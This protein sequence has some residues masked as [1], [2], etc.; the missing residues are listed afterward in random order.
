MMESRLTN[1]T[2]APGKNNPADST[3]KQDDF[4]QS[5][6][7]AEKADSNAQNK[8]TAATASAEKQVSVLESAKLYK[9]KPIKFSSNYASLGPTSTALFNTYQTYT[10]GSG[11]IQ[12]GSGTPLN[13]LITMGISD[14]MEDISVN[15]GLKFGTNL[16]DNEWLISYQNKKR[17][18]DWGLT[19]YRNVEGYGVD[20]YD[21]S[22]LVNRAPLK[23]FTNIY[24]VNVAYPFDVVKSLRL[25]AG[26]RTDNQVVSSAGENLVLPY[27]LYPLLLKDLKRSYFQ[28]HLEFVYDNSQ[29]V[30]V[31]IW[32]GLRYKIFMDYN[33]EVTKAKYSEGRNI[34]NFGFDARHYYPIYRNVIWAMRAAGNFSWGKQKF[35]YYLGGEDGWLMFGSNEK[36]GRQRYFDNNNKPA[37]DQDYAFQSL[38]VNMRGFI[39]NV[40]NG[41][42]AVVIN[43]EIRVPILSTFFNKTISNPFL[44]DLQA[45]QFIDLGSAWNGSYSK[46]GRPSIS[47]S[48]TND[49][50]RDPVI[51]KIKAPGVGP[52]AGGYGLGLRTSLLGYFVKFDMS[53]PMN[54]FFGG[55][56]I[57]YLAL[58]LDF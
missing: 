36:D 19:Y 44:R 3:K 57:K 51:V 4:F 31:N 24:Q 49:P 28:S 50:T 56:P 39:Q 22:G 18:L 30:A 12:L 26:I 1:N 2:A 41:N 5:E 55:R 54:T 13:G 21:S 23:I 15:G 53:W 42:N 35:I 9:Y 27:S 43:S 8:T 34:F 17:R 25:T 7:P 20:I 11:P 45:I 32:N 16:K 29:N 48:A 33:R 37:P 10:G 46:L 6:F 38:A 14:L 40:A 52:F 58:G 47:Y